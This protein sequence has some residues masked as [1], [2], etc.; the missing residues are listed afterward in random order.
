MLGQKLLGYE[1]TER[2]ASRSNWNA[3]WG[4]KMGFHITMGSWRL[5][6][7]VFTPLTHKVALWATNNKGIHE[8]QPTVILWTNIN[9]LNIS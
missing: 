3:L 1:H 4:S 8:N 6:P 5:T 9:P 2:Q 7:G